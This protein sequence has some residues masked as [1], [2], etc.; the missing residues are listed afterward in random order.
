MNGA[1]FEWKGEQFIEQMTEACNMAVGAAAGVVAARMHEN[2]MRVRTGERRVSGKSAFEMTKTGHVKID[3]KTGKAKRTWL[4]GVTGNLKPTTI[5]SPFGKRVIVPGR[6]YFVGKGAPPG[7]F[8]G[9]RSGRFNSSIGSSAAKNLVA[10]AGS[11]AGVGGTV[12]YAMRLE[13]GYFGTDAAGRTYHQ[14]ARPWAMRSA[15]EAIP[16]AT[17]TFRDLVSKAAFSATLA[18]AGRAA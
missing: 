14:P 12:P 11:G 13:Y 8:P 10:Y 6:A 16:E 7:A 9:I 5:D 3:S 4:P 15:R 17:R 18:Q 1:T 2:V